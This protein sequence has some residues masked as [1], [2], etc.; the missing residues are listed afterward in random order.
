MVIFVHLVDLPRGTRHN[1]NY[2]TPMK[3]GDV[4]TNEDGNTCVAVRKPKDHS[5]RRTL[6]IMINLMALSLWIEYLLWRSAYSPGGILI[7]LL[8]FLF[9]LWLLRKRERSL[10]LKA[11]KK[12]LDQRIK[13]A[14]TQHPSGTI[15]L[16]RR[17]YPNKIYGVQ[18]NY[19][20]AL[21]S[22]G[23]TL[24]F[25][26]DEHLEEDNIYL[27][28]LPSG[29]ETDNKELK[30]YMQPWFWERILW[31]T[32]LRQGERLALHLLGSFLLNIF[33]IF[34][35]IGGEQFKYY[36]EVGVFI[37][38]WFALLLLW[39]PL[40]NHFEQIGRPITS[41]AS[42]FFQICIPGAIILW[43][44][45]VLFSL[46]IAVPL[47]VSMMLYLAGWIG[48]GAMVFIVLASASIFPVTLPRIARYIVG[49]IVFR[50]WGSPR[51]GHYAKDLALYMV[52]PKVINCVLSALYV[53]YLVISSFYSIQ[54]QRPI[55]SEGIDTAVMQAF[56]VYLG[57]FALT[58]DVKESDIS[59]R[60]LARLVY[61][62]FP[63][64]NKRKQGYL[65]ATEQSP[66]SVTGEKIEGTPPTSEETEAE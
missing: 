65:S 25:Y 37:A 38:S 50:N 8:G 23:V 9:Y 18:H 5:T 60:E 49:N 7:L 33:F 28:L 16:K 56:L 63:R 59:A 46:G 21:L 42:Y 47:L 2:A 58:R 14:L 29:K 19:V 57:V 45:A 44:Y 20:L 39:L 3:P 1:L 27:E 54:L 66:R 43:G 22:N 17:V 26:Y 13:E 24:E 53:L 34:L 40:R 6:A 61:G 32:R 41:L 64:K 48:G 35:P 55:F 51:E 30:E 62:V 36:W 12:E 10:V 11:F 52:H 31:G 15:E 4:W